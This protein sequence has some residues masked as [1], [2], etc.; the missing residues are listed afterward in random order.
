MARDVGLEIG[1]AMDEP[2]H[3]VPR[4]VGKLEGLGT[5][6]GNAGHRQS[7]EK[8]HAALGS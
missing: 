4:K 1:S 3:D 2:G 8:I 6:M 5:M 7:K